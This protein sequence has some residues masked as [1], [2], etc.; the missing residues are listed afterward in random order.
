MV[1]NDMQTSEDRARQ[2]GIWNA[3]GRF[4][5]FLTKPAPA[6]WEIGPQRQA[7]LLAGLSFLLALSVLSGF[8][9]SLV[10]NGFNQEASSSIAFLG[11]LAFTFTSYLFSRS[12]NYV[13]GTVLLLGA[14]SVISYMGALMGVA[15]PLGF[16]L[17]F[18]PVA[19][20][21]GGVLLS[22]R[23]I[24]I[25]TVS[26]VLLLFFLAIFT[27]LTRQFAGT[28]IGLVI[29][30][31]IML[32]AFTSFRNSLEQARLAEINKANQELQLLSTSLEQRVTERTN[33]ILV[34]AEVGRR[35][36]VVQN[37]DELLS[38]AVE[39]IRDRFDLYYTQ[40]YLVNPN[41]N[42]LII[43]AGTGEVGAELLR[44]GHHLPIDHTSI[45]GT[46]VSGRR[47][48]TV[49]DTSAS[50]IFR[51][52]PLL[53]KTRSEMAIPLISSE[54]TLGVLDLQSSDPGG[55]SEENLPVFQIL[56][57]QLAT[58]LVNAELFG[59]LE[60]TL[61]RAETHSRHGV[62]Q[63]W[64]EYLDAIHVKE[65]IGYVF[66]QVNVR[67][68]EVPLADTQDASAMNIP[69]KVAGEPVG[70]FQFIS[71]RPWSPEHAEMVNSVADQVAQQI[72]NLRLLNQAE[73]YRSEAED[74][75]RRLTRQEWDEFMQSTGTSG[76]GF[77]YAQD[78]VQPVADRLPMADSQDT[79]KAVMKFDIKIR[80]EQIGQFGFEGVD[81][82]SPEDADLVAAVSEQLGAHLENMRLYTTAQQE[83]D[84]RRKAEA[85]IAKRAAELTTVSEVATV[86]AT[87]Q[88]PEEM[89]QTVVDLTK[90]SFELY[91]AHIYLM[92][93]AGNMLVMTKG[94]G[95]VGRQMVTEG[96]QIPY[97]AEKSL[98]ARAARI[99]QGVI[100]ND[101]RED[102]DFL[103]NPLLPDTR[104]EMAVPMVVGDHLLGVLDIQ[105]DEIDHF[106]EEDISIQTTL[107]AQVAVALQNAR[108]YA[109][110][111]ESEQLTRSV[112]DS[113]P[114]WIFIKDKQHRYRLVNQGYAN[115]LKIPM[116][117][118][119][120]KDD[121]ELGFPEEYVKGNPE[122]G[123]RGFWADDRRVMDGG[124]PVL[125]P[126]DTNEYDGKVHIFNTLKT[127]LRDVNGNVWGVLAFCRDVTDREQTLADT[128][129]LYE[130]S[131]QLARS[132]NYRDVLE[133]V[134]QH[135]VFSQFDSATLS[136]YD[137]PWSEAPQTITFL[138][139]Y[140]KEGISLPFKEGMVLPVQSFTNFSRDE[141][142][143][144]MVI[145]DTATDSQI[146]EEVRS[147][148][149]KEQGVRASILW[150]LVI[151]G[152][153]HGMIMATS[154]HP[155]NVDETEKRRLSSLVEQAS[156]MVQSLRLLE[157]AQSRAQ[158]EQVLREITAHVRSSMDPDT[159]LR[160]AVRELGAALGRAA[161]VRVGSAEQLAQ[162]P[163]EAR[164][165]SRG[166]NGAS[167][168]G[169]EGGR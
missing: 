41:G 6:I 149:L 162:K 137:R 30:Y 20:I 72:E 63:G 4:W 119:I 131:R 169:R 104:S 26:N 151:G 164:E 60:H 99:R 107:A 47:I 152:Q 66:D 97:Q 52:H 36:S 42:S 43:H 118:F 115:S 100:V 78:E 145:C 95:E 34:A 117:S 11:V 125:Y 59:R 73:W 28:V 122:K 86:V 79:A 15:D 129:A 128:E 56:A 37:M 126:D 156:T 64:D 85:I 55:L 167:Q 48:V 146:T 5:D 158:H 163:T 88:S 91:H 49:A 143:R 18:L 13:V 160:T 121:L 138:A 71:D 77:I 113:T 159:I 94:A 33:D 109:Q 39:L 75:V 105:S 21:I 80:D 24:I 22:L 1:E 147:I 46:A 120:G 134:V 108:Q 40:V 10:M 50:I 16:A 31:G 92:N 82:L 23:G 76:M 133:A 155:I 12:R 89:L 62:R 90:I 141:E 84:E 35:I 144:E 67:S 136:M 83:L 44:G 29:G 65:R 140:T 168:A 166:G 54:R 87:I 27:N 123:I 157:A 165:D 3:L 57:S 93:E 14:F 114:D 61:A 9:T 2:T 132:L 161:F 32:Y 70:S 154:A 110:T 25:L 53:P 81:E 111:Q 17:S 127:P 153:S 98:V 130:G 112:I 19:F 148:M 102:P 58:A 150:P 101:V 38:Q 103:P 106:S 74:A 8:L 96:R 7:R 135:T 124:E 116:E 68:S 45:N 51:P 69:I 139:T 142:S